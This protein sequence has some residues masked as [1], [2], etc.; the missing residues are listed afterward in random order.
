PASTPRKRASSRSCL[1]RMAVRSSM[2]SHCSSCGVRRW[3][4]R[5]MVDPLL[6]FSP[7]Q[8][9]AHVFSVGE[10]A[11]RI[12]RV[13]EAD[14]VLQDVWLRGE[15]VNV[16]RSPAGHYYFSLKEDTVQLRCVLFKGSAFNSPVMPA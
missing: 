14:P 6:R 1:S 4:C 5:V 3:R 16:S 9:S 8:H 11:Q 10:L 15:V 12:G 2:A 13:L 7:V